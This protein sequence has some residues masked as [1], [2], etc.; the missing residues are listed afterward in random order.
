MHLKERCMQQAKPS[1]NVKSTNKELHNQ[2]APTASPRLVIVGSSTLDGRASSLLRIRPTLM[3]DVQELCV[4]P[5]YLIIDL[6]LQDLVARLKKEKETRFVLAESMDPSVEDRNILVAEGRVPAPRKT[7]SRAKL[8][9]DKDVA[10]DD[11]GKG[12]PN[13]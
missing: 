10:A 2:D 6:A 13:D 1:K 7:V 3:R 9:F 11:D 4:G 8:K 12:V 5:L